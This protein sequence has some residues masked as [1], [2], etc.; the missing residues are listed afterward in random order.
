MLVNVFHACTSAPSLRWPLPPAPPGLPSL[1]HLPRPH[2][3]V[4]EL[5]TWSQSEQQDVPRNPPA[6]LRSP[7]PLHPLGPG[8]PFS[9]HLHQAVDELLTWSQSEQQDVLAAMDAHTA[10]RLLAALPAELRQ[11]LLAGMPSHLAANIVSVGGGG[12]RGPREVR[13]YLQ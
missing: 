11:K 3:A 4:D 13:P 8:P 12:G 2:Q 7:T 5:L 10:A 6:T 1:Q 9:A